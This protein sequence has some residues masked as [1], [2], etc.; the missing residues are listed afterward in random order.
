MKQD[1]LTVYE[2]ELVSIGCSKIRNNKNDDQLFW[3][4]I[5]EN[6][7][8]N[9][10]T[11]RENTED[12]FNLSKDPPRLTILNAQISDSGDYYCCIEYST[13]E[14]KKTVRSKQ[15]HLIIEKSRYIL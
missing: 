2:N 6:D 5:H 1:T 14:R 11:I 8:K 9:K 3:E 7:E 15:A 12:R 10:L 4:R 13:S